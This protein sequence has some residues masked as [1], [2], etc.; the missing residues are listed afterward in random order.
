MKIIC[1]REKLLRAFGTVASVVPARSPKAVLRNVKVVAEA[2]IAVLMGTDLENGIRVELPGMEISEPGE[3]LLPID[4]FGMILRES[5]DEKIELEDDGKRVLVRGARSK[6]QLPSED[7][8]QFPNVGAFSEE[9]CY[10]LPAVFFCELIHRTAFA[11][12]NENSRYALGGVLIEFDGEQINGVATDGRRLARQ[13][14]AVKP[15]GQPDDAERMTIVPTRATQL[16]ERAIAEDEEPI[17]IAVKDNEILVRGHRV[18]VRARLT[19]GRFPNWKAVFPKNEELIK[20]NMP[21]GPFHAAV[22]QAAIVTSKEHRGVDF[23]FGEGK[24]M[25]VAHG[26]ELGESHIEMPVAYDGDSITV[27]LDPNYMSGF[28]KVLQPEQTFDVGIK[29][30]KTAVVCS[31]DDGYSY[32]IMPLERK[33]RKAG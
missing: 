5:S 20:I 26:A 27:K 1:D 7:P 9:N 30:A 11:T 6:F 19:E 22:R 31:T 29:D 4:R 33:E 21:V 25:L 24:I 14:G 17:R 8:S 16:I 18:T 13:T 3:V 2:D 32:V 12:D 23:T 28:L 15:I 10:E